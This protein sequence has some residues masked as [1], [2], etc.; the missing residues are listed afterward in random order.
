MKLYI[1]THICIYIYGGWGEVWL[2]GTLEEAENRYQPT[3]KGGGDKQGRKQSSG[4]ND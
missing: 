1:Y 3:E 4:S 2:G